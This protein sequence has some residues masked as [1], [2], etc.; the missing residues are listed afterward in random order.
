MSAAAKERLW[1]R[2]VLAL[3]FVAFTCSYPYIASVNNPN[4]NVRVYMTMGLVE[5]HTF[6]I[7]VPVARHGWVNDMARVNDKVTGEA[8]HFSVKAPAISYAGV[9]VYWA[10]TKIAP[11]FGHPLPSMDAPASAKAW[12]LRASIFV[13]RLFCVQ[14]PCFFFL[15]WFE[16]FLRHFS[17]DPVLRLTA[18]VAAGLGTNYLAYSLMFASHAPFACAAFGAFGV[19]LRERALFPLDPRRRR[20]SRAFLAGFLAGLVTLL[21]Y[22]ALP[23]SFVL[24]V[25]AAFVFYRPTRLLAFG[26]GAAVN[27]A[28]LMWFQWRSF[29]NPLM[30]GHKLQENQAFV[31]L[32]EHGLFGIGLPSWDVLKQI[33]LSHAFGFFGTSPFMWLGLLAIPFGLIIARGAPYQ[34]AQLRYATIAWMT[35]MLLLWLTVSA[36]INW[37]G[38]WT[39]GPRYLG[40]APPFFAFGAVVALETIASGDRLR[41]ALVRGVAGGLAIASVATIGTIGLLY[42][43][44]PESVTRPLSQVVVP[45]VRAGFV[46]Y[47]AGQLF[48][49][50]APTFWY[51]VL[52]AMLLSAVVAALLPFR[53]RPLGFVV[54][55]VTVVLVAT[56]A[57]RPSLGPQAPGEEGD[58]G[59]EARRSL[60]ASWEPAGHDRITH[61]REEAVRDPCLW[62]RVADLERAIERTADAATDE[63]RAGKPRAQCRLPPL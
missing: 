60:T 31:A 18:V 6:R 7:D 63:K 58:A 13:L 46:P 55:L 26:A 42:N 30:P 28:A 36:A 32:H 4:E 25:Y 29:G 56:L 57:L 44:I 51:F 17:R 43:T 33:S 62:Y 14:L 54:R 22:H 45:F 5:Q 9:P 48:G 49:S 2:L 16:R 20:V 27:V 34:K 38:G 15:V 24:A 8:H 47:H 19:V 1:V 52:G 40:A 21:E 10:F 23:V 41:R 35:A 53:D 59:V 39:I 11:R 3:A 61:L 37:R 50:D 12:W